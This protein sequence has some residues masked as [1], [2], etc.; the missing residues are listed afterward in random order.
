MIQKRI[1]TTHII[2]VILIV[3]ISIVAVFPFLWMLSNSFNSAQNIFKLPPSLI[4]DLLFAENMFENYVSVVT[5]FNFG[6][7]ALNSLFVSSMAAIGQIL[8]CSL[9]GFAF[10]MMRFKGRNLVFSAL[11]LT[12][13]VPVQVTIIPEYFL[14]MKLNWID[15]Y[16][17]LIVPSFL[18][19]AFGTFM[20]K[21]FFEQVPDAIFDAGVIDGA[22]AF[23]MYK[24]VYAPQSVTPTV[25]L[26]IIAFMNSWND[27]LRAMLYITTDSLQTVTLALMQFQGQYEARW[28]LLLTGSVLSVLPLVILFIVCQRFIIENSMSSAV[29]G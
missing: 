10:A 24:D 12:L 20:L 9:A 11:L 8:I 19:G 17:P 2:R 3:L 29:K 26:F 4:P 15:T 13:M 27:L 5:E 14:M 21:E 28:N 18:A 23:T 1:P 6:K 7:Y 25:T 22:N 16:L